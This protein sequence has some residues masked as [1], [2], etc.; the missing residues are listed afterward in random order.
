MACVVRF[1]PPCSKVPSLTLESIAGV[2]LVH[3][4]PCSAVKKSPAYVSLNGG[5]IRT[6]RLAGTLTSTKALL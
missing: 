1:L 5:V 2:K 4:P 6:Y 3:S